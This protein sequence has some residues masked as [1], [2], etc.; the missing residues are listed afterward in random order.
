MY[1]LCSLLLNYGLNLICYELKLPANDSNLLILAS[2]R[3]LD[4]NRGC[5]RTQVTS[6][7]FKERNAKSCQLSLFISHM[8]RFRFYIT[9]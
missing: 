9:R 7:C 6:E 8:T 1:R 4:Y 2:H 3:D 5:H